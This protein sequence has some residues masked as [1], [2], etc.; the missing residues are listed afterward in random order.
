MYTSTRLQLC[1]CRLNVGDV[2]KNAF[3]GQTDIFQHFATFYGIW[4]RKINEIPVIVVYILCLLFDLLEF[5]LYSLLFAI[6]R[7]AFSLQLFDCFFI[8]VFL[9][10]LSRNLSASTCLMLVLVIFEDHWPR[11]YFCFFIWRFNRNLQTDINFY[12][13]L[14]AISFEPHF[15]IS[16][17]PYKEKSATTTAAV[18]AAAAVVVCWPTTLCW[19]LLPWI[20]FCHSVICRHQ[21]LFINNHWLLILDSLTRLLVYSA[22]CCQQF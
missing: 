17:C 21:Q 15:H 16:A 8:R 3:L 19:L 11:S 9:S 10:N 18:A 4:S 7:Q 13:L 12:S 20:M 14:A 22:P 1:C 5:P 6:I 2:I